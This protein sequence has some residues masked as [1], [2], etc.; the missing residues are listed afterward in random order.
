MDMPGRRLPPLSPQ[1][2][3]EVID[4]RS[5]YLVPR[6]RPGNAFIDTASRPIVK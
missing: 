5:A 4:S 2:A 1:V 3:L 6:P